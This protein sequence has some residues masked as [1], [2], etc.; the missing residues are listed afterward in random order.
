MAELFL[1]CIG[2]EIEGLGLWSVY[3]VGDKQ[4]CFVKAL[5]QMVQGCLENSLTLMELQNI[6]EETCVLLVVSLRNKDNNFIAKTFYIL[7]S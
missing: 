3:F 4:C 1:D 2:L 5:F 6:K 7:I